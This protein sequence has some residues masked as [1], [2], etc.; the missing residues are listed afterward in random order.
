MSERLTPLALV[1]VTG[2]GSVAAVRLETDRGSAG[3][4]SFA[5]ANVHDATTRQWGEGAARVPSPLRLVPDTVVGRAAVAVVAPSAPGPSPAAVAVAAAPASAAAPAPAAASAPAAPT[6]PPAP[7]PGPA[8]APAAPAP[9]AA[10]EVKRQLFRKEALDAHYGADVDLEALAEPKRGAWTALIVLGSLVALLFIG[11]GLLSIEVTVKAPGALRAPNGLRS[12]ESVLGGAVTEV[13][14]HAGDDVVAG[15]VVARLEDTKLRT[16]LTLREH[17]LQL[18]ERDTAEASQA[19]AAM[20]RSATVAL[21]RQRAA[22]R[23]RREINQA[24]LRQRAAHLKN[25]KEL[26]KYGAASAADELTVNESVQAASESVAQLGSQVAQLELSMADRQREW[27]GRDL[28]RRTSLSRAKAAV[29]EA[30]SLLELVHIRAPAEGRIES[31][32]TTPGAVV[33]AGEILAQIVPKDAPRSIVAFLPSRETAFVK[34]GTLANVEVESLPINEFGMARARVT[35]ISADIAKAEEL[36]AAFG[37]ALPGSFVRVE[38]SLE[39][40][41]AHD[42]MS[43]HLR[44]GERVLVRLHRRERRILS[45]LFEFVRKWLGQ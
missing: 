36:E 44:S 3:S 42:K 11:A 13:L 29:E 2:G 22:L 21:E 4:P 39:D 23:Q 18:L 24:Q 31:L 17:E 12:V 6:R 10:P 33:A 41:D 19:D 8:P 45:L 7:T 37:E 15:Q 34:L 26:V 30:E 9:P 1:S 38:L 35:R 14:A 16:T 5:M 43:A 40:D 20:L 25:L 28:E 27:Q 32:L